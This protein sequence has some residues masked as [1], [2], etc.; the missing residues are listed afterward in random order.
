MTTSFPEKTFEHWVSQYI[1]YRFRTHLGQWWPPHGADVEVDPTM[2]PI[3]KAIWLELK[4]ATPQPGDPDVHDVVLDV[5]QLVK[6]HAA[7]I[8]PPVYYVIPR[9]GWEGTLGT[10]SARPWLAGTP[11]TDLAFTRSGNLWFGNWTRVIAGWSLYSALVRTGSVHQQTAKLGHWDGTVWTWGPAFAPTARA[12][13]EWSWRGFWD[14]WVRC[15]DVDM[16]SA[17]VLP[18]VAAVHSHEDSSP[19]SDLVR[20]LKEYGEASRGE[21]RS[22]DYVARSLFLPEMNSQGAENQLTGRY[23][24]TQSFSGVETGDRPDVAVPGGT[25]ASMLAMISARD[26]RIPQ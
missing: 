2:L 25:D 4:T 10:R 22:A 18:P 14:A 8:K 24:R 16:P 11:R 1:T 3:G 13:P 20:R 9:P 15:G 5:P 7:G 23:R 21:D 12:H 26:L 6:Y 19:R 17:I